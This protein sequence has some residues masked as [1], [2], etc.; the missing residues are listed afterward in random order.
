MPAHG[1]GHRRTSKCAK[2]DM[3]R[4]HKKVKPG[5]RVHC[6]APNTGILDPPFADPPLRGLRH[7]HCALPRASPPW[8]HEDCQH[9]GIFL[10]CWRDDWSHQVDCPG[11][12]RK[13]ANSDPQ[14]FILHRLRTQRSGGLVSWILRHLIQSAGA[15]FLVNT[16]AGAF[17]VCA[18]ARLSACE[19]RADGQPRLRRRFLGAPRQRRARIRRA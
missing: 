18:L 12:R 2:T 1:S 9:L 13:Q 10:W 7:G 19:N 11:Y 8:V 3:H 17:P 4:E 6:F 15:P 14:A 5:C 16:P